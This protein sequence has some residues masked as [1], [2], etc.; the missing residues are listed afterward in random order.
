MAG[1]GGGG[2]QNTTT[3]QVQIP[4]YEQAFSQS[5]QNLAQ[6]LA[7]QPYPGYQGALIQ[8]MNAAQG[9]GQQQAIN[10]AFNYQPEFQSAQ[11]LLDYTQGLTG[12]VYSS[13]DQARGATQAGQ[14]A[15]QFNN[16]LNRAQG[17]TATG[18]NASN[19]YGAQNRQGGAAQQA[20]NLTNPNAVAGYMNPFIQ[21][22]LAP[23][24][25]DLQLQLAGQQQGINAQAAQSGAFGDAR[26][27]A[28]AAL[29]NLYGNQAMNQLIGTG[30]N[31]AFTQALAALGQAQ[32]TQ[33]GAAGQ[34]GNMAQTGLGEQSA[35]LQAGQN[36]ANQAGL[37]NQQQGLQL[38]AGQNYLAQ[39]G[40]YN[41]E[42]N[43]LAAEAAQRAAMANQLQ[44]QELTGAN[45]TYNVGQQQQQQGQSELNAAY[46]QYLNQVN[47][48]YQMLNVRESALANSPYN[49]QTAVTL[50]NANST[51]QGFGILAG[52]AGLLGQLGGGGSANVAPFGGVPG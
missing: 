38:Q 19:V 25:Q 15:T 3:S 52:A 36:F 10:S 16:S 33:L 12:N 27:G 21:Q 49:I 30:Y 5:N 41:T 8:P 22:A 32:G 26:Q 31:N 48:P 29:Q 34:Y 2:N 7:S 46:Q 43:S 44:Q 45:A 42:Q 23:Q 40:M 47:W 24:I 35:Q 50:P 51:A 37:A 4:A 14:N 20:Q 6:S 11:S 28:Q 39:G 9:S 18:Q 17:A 13:I 1:G